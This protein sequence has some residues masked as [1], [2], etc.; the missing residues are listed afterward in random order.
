M[1]FNKEGNVVVAKLDH[2]SDLFDNLLNIMENIDETCGI[3][4]SGIGMI[5]DFKLGY[6]NSKTGNYEWKEYNEPMELLSISGS[7]TDDGSIHMHAQVADSDHHVHGGHLDKG[8]IY[9]VGEITLLVF[10]DMILTRE[11]DE[12]R[13]MDLL[14]VK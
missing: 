8:K 1:E 6:Y 5:D 13:D 4:N 3:I 10:K 7:I 14:S 9:N 12:E 2:N 11:K